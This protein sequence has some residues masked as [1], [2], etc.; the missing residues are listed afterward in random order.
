MPFSSVAPAITGSA[1]WR[2]RRLASSRVNRRSR[3]AASVAPLRDTPGTSARRLG[4]PEPQ[5]VA[6]ARLLVAARSCGARSAQ[7]ITTEPASSPAAIVAGVPSRR[8]IG[9]SSA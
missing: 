8:S 7:A 3:A 6:R 5:R 9:R 4:D 2:E 1:T